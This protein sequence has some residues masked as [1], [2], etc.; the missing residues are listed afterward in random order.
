MFEL[1]DEVASA[2]VGVLVPG[3]VLFAEVVVGLSVVIMVRVAVRMQWP[4]ATLGSHPPDRTTGARLVSVG[5]GSETCFA[6][7]RLTQRVR[8]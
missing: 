6:P 4:T 2:P 8:I 5:R 3:V 7:A 1:G